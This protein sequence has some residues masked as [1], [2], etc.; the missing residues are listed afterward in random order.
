MKRD[1]EHQAWQSSWSV[2]TKKFCLVYVGRS[3]VPLRYVGTKNCSWMADLGAN[4]FRALVG[5]YR[6]A[7]LFPTVVITP[8]AGAI[9]DR[10]NRLLDGKN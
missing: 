3:G 10:T 5:C 2:D 6:V 4:Q 1:R 8:I 9:A 7:D